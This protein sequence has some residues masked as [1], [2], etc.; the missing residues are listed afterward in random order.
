MSKVKVTRY[1]CDFCGKEMNQKEYDSSK[2]VITNTHSK[3]IRI[4]ICDICDS[5]WTKITDL[6]TTDRERRSW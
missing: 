2:E 3:D 4:P 6:Q 1:Y 5:C